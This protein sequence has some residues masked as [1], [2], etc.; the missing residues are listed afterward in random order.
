VHI[1]ISQNT[2]IAVLSAET[3]NN[4][5]I[6][7]GLGTLHKTFVTPGYLCLIVTKGLMDDNDSKS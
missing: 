1:F 3:I 2:M 5:M 4:N 7:V 6:C